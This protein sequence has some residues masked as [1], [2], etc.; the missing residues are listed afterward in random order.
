MP[1]RVWKSEGSR[2]VLGRAVLAAAGA[3]ALVVATPVDRAQ[4]HKK[5]HHHGHGHHGHGHGHHG[6]GHNEPERPK[7]KLVPGY[8]LQQTQ[9]YWKRSSKGGMEWVGTGT[10]NTKPVVR[11]HTTPK[12]WTGKVRDNR[13]ADHPSRK[14]PDPADSPG[15]VTVGAPN[16]TGK[17]GGFCNS[18]AWQ[19]RC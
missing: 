4:A 12:G 19:L 2:K 11:D 6:G 15:G 16:A 7:Y 9:G 10:P 5:H 17:P 3:V 13:P 18:P 8:K 14:D 1:M